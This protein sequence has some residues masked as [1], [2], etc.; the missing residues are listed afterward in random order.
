MNVWDE[1]N[2]NETKLKVENGRWNCRHNK[3][4]VFETLLVIGKQACKS[5]FEPNNKPIKCTCLIF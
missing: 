5:V 4:K 3:D 2:L 1:K